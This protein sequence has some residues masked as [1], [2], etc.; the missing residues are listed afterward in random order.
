MKKIILFL[1]AALFTYSVGA[2][3]VAQTN[4]GLPITDLGLEIAKGNVPGHSAEIKWGDSETLNTT[5]RT[6]WGVPDVDDNYFLPTPQQLKVTSSSANDAPGQLG[7][8]ALLIF[9][10]DSDGKEAI[11][12]LNLAGQTEVTTVATMSAVNRMIVKSAGS[13]GSNQG[14]IYMFDGTSTAGVPD[15]T[16]K[17]VNGITIDHNQTASAF[18]T[19]PSNKTAFIVGASFGV[20]A[21]KTGT[22]KVRVKDNGV[23]RT[24][25]DF[26]QTSQWAYPILK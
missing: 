19:V 4:R 23:F 17:I 6:I 26:D 24:A 14:T 13:S 5:E 15:D 22:F 8:T 2:V 21:N 11:E 16:T 20:A 9:Y 12:E 1:I 25:F 18:Y 7:A 3:Q 10:L